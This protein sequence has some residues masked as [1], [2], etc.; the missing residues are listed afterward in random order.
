MGLIGLI[1]KGRVIMGF[2][3]EEYEVEAAPQRLLA[4]LKA[5]LAQQQKSIPPKWFYDDLGS[6]LFEDIT[7]L[8]EYYPTEAERGI[9]IANAP[10]M[11]A[12]TGS[13]TLV[14]L[15]AGISDKTTALIDAMTEANGQLPWYVPFDISADAIVTGAER[16]E[17][18]YPG[19]NIHGIT[20]DFDHH[21]GHI[22]GEGRRMI[23]LLGGTIGNY[24]PEPRNELL[25]TIA[26]TMKPEDSFLLGTDLVKDPARLVAAYDDSAGVTAE[27]NRNVIN[28]IASTLDLDVSV[29]Q[30]A[31]R[32][33]WNPVE[34]WIEVYLDALEE[35]RFDLDGDE[36]LIENGEAILTEISAK[37][38]MP[39][40]EQDLTDA[41]LTLLDSWTD[42]DFMVSLSTRS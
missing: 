27:F 5:G 8:P 31:H 25:Q 35:V 6:K 10:A 41:G 3:M 37:F 7:R 18:R 16:L 42:G 14:E 2:S 38:T 30:F 28:V 36:I 39:R 32:A 20:G 4:D 12:A 26:T 21:L 15:G 1:R 33:I 24:P 29:E 40:L 11:V 9:L 17:A 23:A 22:G 13:N 19:I 34:E